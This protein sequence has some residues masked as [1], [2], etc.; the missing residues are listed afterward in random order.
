MYINTNICLDTYV[1]ERNYV[2]NI[3]PTS[4]SYI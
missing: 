3:I 2:Y 4:D 1:E